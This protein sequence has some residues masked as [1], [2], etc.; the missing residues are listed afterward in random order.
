MKCILFFSIFSPV[1]EG[2]PL[3]KKFW[4]VPRGPDHSCKVM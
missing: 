2:H 4:N 3:V 1:T